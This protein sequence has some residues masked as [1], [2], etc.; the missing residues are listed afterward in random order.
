MSWLYASHGIYNHH[1]LGRQ[2]I[3]KGRVRSRENEETM[4]K[5]CNASVLIQ[6]LPKTNNFAFAAVPLTLPQTNLAGIT[7]VA[8]PYMH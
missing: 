6:N 8:L 2:N 1:Q 5:R 4:L 7:I 3:Q